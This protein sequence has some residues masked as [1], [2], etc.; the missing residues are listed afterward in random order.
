MSLLAAAALVAAL[1]ASDPPDSSQ[2]GSA[3][4]PA[5]SNRAA[6]D[7][8]RGSRGS[9]AGE[10][11]TGPPS[12]GIENG[13]ANGLAGGRTDEGPRG[14]T[15]IR[16]D[17][18]AVTR[19]RARNRANAQARPR[20]KKGSFD[21]PADT[22]PDMNR[23]AK[24]MGSGVRRRTADQRPP[25]TKTIPDGAQQGAA[26]GVASDPEESP[27]GSAPNGTAGKGAGTQPDKK[28]TGSE[29]DTPR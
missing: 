21:R 9:T 28:Q 29:P 16:G 26:G 15:G 20:N 22:P 3:P 8:Q 27:G 14:G 5:Q 7:A 24:P 12:A 17:D 11:R 1:A 23:D 2:R 4:T 25:R 13:E 10:E 18:E 6:D 19:D